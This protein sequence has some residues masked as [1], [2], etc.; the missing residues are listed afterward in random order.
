MRRART[1]RRRL[2]L[3]FAVFTLAVATLF[4]ALALVFTY[5]VEDQFFNDALRDEAAYLLE[6]HSQAGTWVA[7]RFD[8]MSLHEN[9]STTSPDLRQ[10]LRADPT[11]SE[12]AG[13]NGRHYHVRQLPSTEALLVAEVSDQLVVRRM[14]DEI[15]RWLAVVASVVVALALL[16]GSWLARQTAEPLA[17]LSRQVEAMRP[18]QPPR[19]FADNQAILEIGVLARGLESL[20]LRVHAFVEREQ[21]FTRDASHEL[22]TP[23][24]VIHSACERLG[25]DAQLSADARRQVDF[26]RQSVWQL[27]QTVAALLTLARDQ[28]ATLAAESVALLPLIEQ[29]IV[30]Q[31]NL[32]YGKPVNVQVDVPNDAR[33]VLPPSV[34][35]MLLANLIANAFAH[36]AAGFVRINVENGRLRIVN[37]D[38]IDPALT[39]DLHQPSV[40]G[41]AST[42]YGFGLAIVERLCDR[43]AIDFQIAFDAHTTRASFAPRRV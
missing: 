12:F 29:V 21:A 31:S 17:A 8:Y 19:A 14:R 18:A 9:V 13:D 3:A 33:M 42:G 16:V 40:K 1:L 25:K 24:A 39:D 15:L 6:H 26:M 32:L 36:S 34:L 23:L 2:M 10:G 20:S 4:G 28:T 5:A 41:Q 38:Q 22:R 7:P 11:R 35:H 27:E 30:E 43:H 37:S